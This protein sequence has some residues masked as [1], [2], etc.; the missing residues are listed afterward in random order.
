MC[1]VRVVWVERSARRVCRRVEIDTGRRPGMGLWTRQQA[2]E[3][4][5]GL[6]HHSDH[7]LS[8]ANTP[9]SATPAGSP[10]PAR[11]P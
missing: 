11:S 10:T 2:D 3:I 4:V 8:P 6:I 9:Q 1:Q 7:R 5:A